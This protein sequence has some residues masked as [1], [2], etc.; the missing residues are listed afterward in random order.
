MPII[1]LTGS[2]A[3]GKSTVAQMFGQLGARVIDADKLA[4]QVMWRNGECYKSVVRLFGKEVLTRGVI[5]RRKIAC[6]VFDQPQKL[7][8]LTHIIHPAVLKRI[9]KVTTKLKKSK[10]HKFLVLD[11]PLLFEVNW[12]Q[13]CDW[14]VVVRASKVQQIKRANQH[15]GMTNAQAQTRIKAQWPLNKK[16]RLADFIIDNSKTINQT[17]KQV[18]DIWQKIRL[19]IKK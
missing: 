3:T 12:D 8:K 1:G 16:I 2:L 9:Q 14:T 7:K 13:Y 5:D 10:K 11:V 18:S 4:H 6:F 15:K 17:K 19:K